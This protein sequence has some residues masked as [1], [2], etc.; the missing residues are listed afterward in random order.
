MTKDEVRALFPKA[1]AIYI[2]V[3]G[4]KVFVSLQ[5]KTVIGRYNFAVQF[6]FTAPADKLD[7]IILE[8][9]D[10]LMNDQGA[11]VATHF[12]ELLQSQY[13]TGEVSPD[14]NNSDPRDIDMVWVTAEKTRITL[15]FYADSDRRS[16]IYHMEILYDGGRLQGASDL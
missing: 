16:G 2:T 1:E 9:R 15:S 11:A 3:D 10:K 8:C 4:H 5:D 13:G 7:R 6:Y 12:V 14:Q